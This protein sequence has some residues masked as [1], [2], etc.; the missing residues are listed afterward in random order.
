MDLTLPLTDYHLS[1]LDLDS[2]EVDEREGIPE[3]LYR[4]P[5]RLETL[6]L[7]NSKV[8]D[9]SAPFIAQCSN[10]RA[11]HVAETKITRPPLPQSSTS[12]WH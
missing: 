11:L 9:E 2:F 3:D 1:G 8:T 4:G 6:I 5:V 7:D 12:L 10:L